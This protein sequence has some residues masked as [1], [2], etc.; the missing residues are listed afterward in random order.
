MKKSIIFIFFSAIINMAAFAQQSDTTVV[1]NK[2]I[3]D[4]G[5]I[6]KSDGNQ[7]YTF[8]FTNKSSHPV[9][10]QKVTTSCGCTTSGWTKDPVEP[11]AK[12]YVT[13]VYKPS[14]ATAFNKSVTVNIE[15]EIPVVTVL[16]IRGNVIQ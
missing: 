4:F 6:T 5:A 15:G 3:H 13:V 12:G 8:E 1:F 2:L 14:G 9:I 11:G 10:I 7:T 16:Q